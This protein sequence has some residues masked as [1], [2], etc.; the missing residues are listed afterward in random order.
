[1]GRSRIFWRLFIVLAGLWAATWAVLGLLL[2]IGTAGWILVIVAVGSLAVAVAVAALIAKADP[3]LQ[4]VLKSQR[5]QI[6][7]AEAVAKAEKLA[8]DA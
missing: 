7:K 2:W 5:D 8:Q 1:M 3:Q 4:E 6:Q